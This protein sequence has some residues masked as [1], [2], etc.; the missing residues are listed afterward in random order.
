ALPAKPGDV[1]AWS[2]RLLHWGSSSTSRA[3][4]P[5]VALSFSV[6]SP[7]FEKP[8]L[9]RG[10]RALPYPS[11]EE[12]LVLC[13]YQ[14]AMYAQHIPLGQ[15]RALVASIFRRHQQLLTK[16]AIEKLSPEVIDE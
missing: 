9:V 12:R 16:E 8:I 2:H 15:T 6:A 1:Y 14:L 13:A 4:C 5:R 7:Q 10:P 3:S 11:W